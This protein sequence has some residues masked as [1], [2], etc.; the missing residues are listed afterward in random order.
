MLAEAVEGEVKAPAPQVQPRRAAAPSRGLFERLQGWV[1]FAAIDGRGAK[2]ARASAPFAPRGSRG[3]FILAMIPGL[4][5]LLATG[6]IF[7][8]PLPSDPPALSTIPVDAPPQTPAEKKLIRNIGVLRDGI[9][10]AKLAPW[11]SVPYKGLGRVSNPD[12][13]AALDALRGE[14]AAF[15]AGIGDH[16][17][18]GIHRDAFFLS[19]IADFR[20]RLH[21]IDGE[22]H[23]MRSITAYHLG[24]LALWAGDAADAEPQFRSVIDIA[25]KTQ[26][27][28]AE[29]RQRL[30]GI[31]AS[32]SYGLGLAEAARGSWKSAI[33]DFDGALTAACRAAA[34]GGSN[35]QADF[36]FALGDA[37]LV[38]LDTRS[39]RNDRL[40]ALLHARGDE[41]ARTAIT[42]PTCAQ[43]QAPATAPSGDADAEAR[44]LSASLAVAGD[45]TLAANLELRAA[46]TGD[47][48]LV[49]QLNFD[50]DGVSAEAAQA[51]TLARAIAG[52][53]PASDAVAGDGVD[54]SALADLQ[55]ISVLKARLAAQLRNGTLSEPE[56]DPTWTWSDPALFVDWKTATASALADSILAEAQGVARDNPELASALYGAVIDNRG[57]LPAVAVSD[58]WWRL[59]TGTSLGFVATMLAVAAALTLALLLLLR[60]WRETYRTTFESYHHSDRLRAPES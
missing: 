17:A 58:A 19:Q 54:K 22:L 24:L 39:I 4:L 10:E 51:Q 13:H 56:A 18:P 8:R 11:S 47:R 2:R 59:N 52:L 31:A 5:L 28:D 35:T 60:R 25:A 27:I 16:A 7:W 34:D 42:S 46:L 9:W 20:A 57:W 1:L 14:I 49:Q 48:D 40:V 3:F 50:A 12:V 44:A 33:A 45:T 55:K 29:G 53:E 30:D 41:T 38:A 23:G 37:N 6:V 15:G 32:A 43:L 26:P 21:T 36:G